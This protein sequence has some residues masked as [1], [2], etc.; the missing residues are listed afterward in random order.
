LSKEYEK[1]EESSAAF[2][3]IA[4]IDMILAKKLKENF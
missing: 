3:Q 4:F 2:I 1:I